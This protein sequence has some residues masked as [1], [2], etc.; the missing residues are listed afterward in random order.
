MAKSLLIKDMKIEDHGIEVDSSVNIY[1]VGQT[2]N[3]S[4]YDSIM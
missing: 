3:N 4:G 2:R 1:I